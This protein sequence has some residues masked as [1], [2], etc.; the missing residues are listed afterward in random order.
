MSL[1]EFSI[2]QFFAD[3]S[4][5]YE[6]RNVDAKTAIECAA[7]LAGSVGGRLGTTKRI[8]VTDGGDCTCFEWKHGEGVTFPPEAAGSVPR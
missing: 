8:I 2:C 5:D 3:D 1:G 4:Y 6:L 7:R